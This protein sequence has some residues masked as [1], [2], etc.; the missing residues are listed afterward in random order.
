MYIRDMMQISAKLDEFANFGKPVHITGCSVPSAVEP[1]PADHWG[2]KV[3]VTPA[4]AWRQPWSPAAQADWLEA[5]YRIALSKPF[6][7]TVC[8]R[9]LADYAGHYIP[10]GGL[11]NKDMTP[12]PAHDRLRKFRAAMSRRSGR[13]RAADPAP[14]N[15]TPP[16][17]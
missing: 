2:G 11:C 15:E 12:K 4:G 8:W 6:V 7:A 5:F 17:S 16:S 3:A 10:H 14:D 13:A 9:D 1:D